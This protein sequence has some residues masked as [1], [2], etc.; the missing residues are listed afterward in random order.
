[1]SLC[2]VCLDVLH[3]REGYRR[4]GAIT[5]C[6]DSAAFSHHKTV[7]SLRTSSDAGCPICRS[8]WAQLDREQQTRVENIRDVNWVTGM[9]IW[10]SAAEASNLIEV[11]IY[12]GIDIS[13][14]GYKEPLMSHFVLQAHEGKA[15]GFCS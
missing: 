1:M 12:T 5:K 7:T 10:M 2:N 15:S 3:D 14:E 4:T 8:F 13:D 6:G 9:S 11:M